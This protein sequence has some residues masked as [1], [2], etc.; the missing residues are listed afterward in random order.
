TSRP[1]GSSSVL[2]NS[3]SVTPTFIPDK[4]GSYT[5]RLT[6]DNG[7]GTDSADVTVST[8]N[9]AP[10]ANAGP[11]QTVA[12]FALVTLNGSGSS[13]V[14][15]DALIYSWTLIARPAGSSAALFGANT[16]TPS[17]AADKPGN[18]VAQ[19][20]VNDGKIT[21]AA[22]TVTITTNAPLPPTANAGPNQTVAHGS[23][24]TLNGA[25]ADV[26]GLSLTYQWSLNTKPAGST[27]ALSNAASSSPSFV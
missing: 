8:T 2:L 6:V 9:S 22:A 7:A 27:A 13:D 24:V 15:G 25:G 12:L 26:Q 3:S 23:T 18:Y 10:V 5:I 19:L 4:P 17:F 21:S 11:N 16:V 14:D 1:L 20:I